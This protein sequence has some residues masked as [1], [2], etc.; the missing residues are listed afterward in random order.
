MP[1]VYPYRRRPR[2]DPFAK[3]YA[4]GLLLV[5]LLVGPHLGDLSVPEEPAVRAKPAPYIR[6]QSRSDDEPDT[7][8][9][10]RSSSFGAFRNCTE[11]RA[12]GRQDI[13]ADDPRYGSH[14]DSDSDGLG[15]E[16]LPPKGR[17]R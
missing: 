10:Q 7:R 4:P 6:L 13:P 2:R 14:L 11:A 1:N 3:L 8:D 12:A 5:A 9:T 15:C 16:P 17:G